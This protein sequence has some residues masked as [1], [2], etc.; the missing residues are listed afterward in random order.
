MS[1]FYV[2]FNFTAPKFSPEIVV[3]Y[4]MFQ[5]IELD[6]FKYGRMNRLEY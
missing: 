6:K 5:G 1:S 4:S 3:N 2:D